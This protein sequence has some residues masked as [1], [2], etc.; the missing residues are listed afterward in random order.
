MN[1]NSIEFLFFFFPSFLLLYFIFEKIVFLKNFNLIII[2]F[3]SCLFYIYFDFKYFVI[4]I[5]SIVMNYILSTYYSSTKKKYVLF[6]SIF[7]NL[8]P[9]IYFKYSVDLINFFHKDFVLSQVI[10]PLGISFLTFQQLSYHFDIYQDKKKKVNF[11]K[12][13]SFM[14][15]FPQLIAGPIIKINEFYP[16]ILKKK[17]ILRNFVI[18]IAIFIIGLS[19]KVLV[20]DHLTYYVDPLFSSE[21]HSI[22]ATF[23]E[24]WIGSISYTFQIYFDFSGYSDMALGMAKIIG[25]NF[26]SNFRSP[27]KENSIIN[28]WRCWHITLTRFTTS[29]IFNP[30]IIYFSNFSYFKYRYNLNLFFSILITFFI[31][32]IWHG[33]GKNFIIFGVLHGL[34]FLINYYFR[35][36]K[37]NTKLEIID[38]LKIVKLFY[39]ILT[40]LSIVIAFIFFR[41]SNLDQSL[42]IIKTLFNFEK[43][44][45]PVTL[46]QYF[47]NLIEIFNLNNIFFGDL[48]LLKDLNIF[49]FLIFCFIVILYMPNTEEI[50]FNFD[51][52]IKSKWKYFFFGFLLG[53]FLIISIFSIGQSISFL[54]YQF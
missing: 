44:I 30:I 19:K 36:L 3:F 31:I 52:I 7:L 6:L 21:L 49:F 12:Y 37:K 50:M 53:V 24:A 35:L 25:L 15:F 5:I 28:F 51:K 54:Y 41:S 1:F 33:S 4:L 16:Q 42:I 26:P 43:I 11:I 23:F 47:Q 9:L 34:F 38:N 2:I 39:L 32:G 8:S 17:I 22:N 40:F 46:S 48:R 45:L 18:G 20:A 27:L 10:L 14:I 29:Y 13:F